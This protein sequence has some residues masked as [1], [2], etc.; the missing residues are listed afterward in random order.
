MRQA[1]PPVAQFDPRHAGRPAGVAPSATIRARPL[2]RLRR[3]VWC[4]AALLARAPVRGG[5]RTP[6]PLRTAQ[7]SDEGWR[8]EMCC[9]RSVVPNSNGGWCSRWCRRRRCLPLSPP[10]AGVPLPD[11]PNLQRPGQEDTCRIRQG[12]STASTELTHSLASRF[13]SFPSQTNSGAFEA[14]PS[15]AIPGLQ[16]LSRGRCV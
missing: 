13:I 16:Q 3:A 14:I 7:G 6:P 9:Q 4:P 8:E 15:L 10:L 5:T 1:W 12:R 11:P 2:L